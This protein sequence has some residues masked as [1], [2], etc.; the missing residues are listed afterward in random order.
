MDPVL[1][2]V[3]QEMTEN[4]CGFDYKRRLLTEDF[5]VLYEFLREEFDRVTAASIRIATDHLLQ[6][7]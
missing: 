3:L 2:H 7:I 1:S 4:A 6:L 5:I